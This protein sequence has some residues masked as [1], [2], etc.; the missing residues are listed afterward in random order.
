[1]CAKPREPS[2]A[3]SRTVRQADHIEVS[4]GPDVRDAEL[5]VVDG[6]EHVEHFST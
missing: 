3:L 1:M 5:A 2:C 6:G 4:V